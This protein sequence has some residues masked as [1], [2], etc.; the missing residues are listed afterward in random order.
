MRSRLLRH[1]LLRHGRVAFAVLAIT[2]AGLELLG[3][4]TG[5]NSYFWDDRRLFVSKGAIRPVGVEGL[6]TYAPHRTIMSAAT[7][8]FSNWEGWLEYR[9]HF[10]TNK[11]GLIDTNY[12][13]NESAVDYL[14]LGDSFTEGQGGCPWLNRSSLSSAGPKILNGGLQ[15]SSILSFELLEQWLEPQ[16]RI[17]NIVLMVISNDFKRALIP[18]IWRDSAACLSGGICGKDDYIWAVDPET[19]DSGLVELSRRSLDL[20][21]RSVPDQLAATLRYHSTTYDIAARYLALLTPRESAR[22][23]APYEANFQA[24]LRLRQ[25]YSSLKIIH[26]PQKDEVGP[27]GVE[28]LD[29]MTV[30]RFLADNRIAYSSCG[31]ALPDFM[32]IDGHPNRQ[33][34]GKLLA[35]LK[36]ATES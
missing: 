22:Q 26:I 31:L 20:Q 2:I 23:P 12:N 17:G 16:V 5:T 32:P 29:T 30:R 34:Y 6:W 36:K 9:C 15:G 3:S 13:D 4:L 11:F 25:K 7:Y 8:R 14:V 21:R 18:R 1:G 28:N 33:G 35:C 27:L 10:E 24:L 19:P